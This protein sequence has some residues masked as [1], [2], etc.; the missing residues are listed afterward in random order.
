MSQQV[1][2]AEE[3]KEYATTVKTFH[4]E[5]W[6][7]LYDGTFLNKSTL[8]S[9]EKEIIVTD[10]ANIYHHIKTVRAKNILVAKRKWKESHLLMMN[11]PIKKIIR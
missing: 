7:N 3:V 11:D 8:F 5:I 1:F 9:K 2:S 10:L 6:I 4:K